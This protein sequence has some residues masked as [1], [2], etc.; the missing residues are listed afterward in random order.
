M[1]A[2][3]ASFQGSP[4]TLFYDDSRVADPLVE[5]LSGSNGKKVAVQVLLSRVRIPGVRLADDQPIV[6]ETS[7]L[8][9]ARFKGLETID[10]FRI[11]PLGRFSGHERG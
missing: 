10:L 9:A 4:L 8:P 7:Y 1:Q 5:G 3:D 2:V 6:T 11:G